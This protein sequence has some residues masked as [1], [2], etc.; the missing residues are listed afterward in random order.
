VT[1]VAQSVL[2]DPAA[3]LVHDLGA[4][5]DHVEGI[6]HRDRVVQAVAD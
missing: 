1:A 6:Q 2:L 3:D 5:L 4:E